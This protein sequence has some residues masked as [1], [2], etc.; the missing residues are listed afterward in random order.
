M[1]EEKRYLSCLLVIYVHSVFASMCVHVRSI[2]YYDVGTSWIVMLLVVLPE[3]L[4][5][6]CLITTDVST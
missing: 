3:L 6:F 1:L 4:N 5:R 2:P